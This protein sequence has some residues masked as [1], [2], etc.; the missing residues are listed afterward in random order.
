MSKQAEI[1]VTIAKL[2]EVAYSKNKGVTTKIVRSKGNYKLTVD[3]KGTVSLSGSVGMLTFKG[4]SALQG[5]GAKLKNA[6]ISF[7]KGDSNNIKYTA[8]FNFISAAS[9]SVSGSFDIEELIL[10]CSGLLC[11]AAKAL[12]GRHAAYEAQLQKIM[13]H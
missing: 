8:T 4:D 7:T 13:G 9:I 3:E 11:R 12:K 1:K 10:S 5:L 2:L 6:S